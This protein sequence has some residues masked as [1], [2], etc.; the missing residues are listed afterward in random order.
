MIIRTEKRH[1]GHVKSPKP[2][3]IRIGGA[4]AAGTTVTITF[5][6]PV[7]LMRTVLPRYTVDVA[8]ADV[9][10]AAL[11]SPAVLVVTYD[12]SVAAATTLT[13]PVRDPAVRNAAGGYV[14]DTTFP[15]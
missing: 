10:A 14:A 12:V 3:A 6:Q 1:R 5:D 8:G 7:T 15:V 4:V 11:T 13:I 2:N 9:V